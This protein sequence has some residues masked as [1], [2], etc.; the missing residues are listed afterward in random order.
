M[1]EKGPEQQPGRTQVTS[2][3][4][5]R[6]KRARFMDRLQARRAASGRPATGIVS[7]PEPR[8]AGQFARGKQLLAGN[9]RFAGHLIEAPD[10]SPWG[11]DI[12][13][14]AYDD[15]L[16]GFAWLDD[17]GA[18][19]DGK[20]RVAA[21]AWVT[22]WI[23]LYGNGKGPGWTPDLTGRRLI[24]WIGHALMILRAQDKAV[25]DRF[26]RS[27]AQQTIFL[28]RRSRSAK[29]GLPRFE[30]LTGLIYASLSLIGMD[31][32]LEAAVADLER[33]CAKLIDVDGALV[34]RNPEELLEVFTLLAWAA[35][36]LR[37]NDRQ[38]GPEH[39]AALNRIAPTIRALR[40]ADG[41]LAR[42]HGG[43]RG[44]DG[45]LD[46]AL[47]TAENKE[48]P[49]Q[50][51]YMGYARASAGRCTV[52]ADFAPPPYGP[53]CTEA[54]A[55]TLAFELTSGRRPL[56]VNC[57]H[58]AHFGDDWRRA[59]RATPS[60]STLTLDGTS[61][62]RIE[63]NR[64]GADVLVPGP[65]DVPWDISRT[66]EMLRLEAGHD[67]WRA[68]HG[69]THARTLDLYTDGRLFIGEDI[70]TTLAEEDETRFDATLDA[71]KLQGIPF[72]LRFHLHPDVNAS[73]DMNGSAV[74]L[75]LRS[76]EIWIFRVDGDVELTL[77]PSVYLENGRLRPRSSTQVVLSGTVLSYSTR[78]RWAFSKA[79]E[80]P[81]ASRDVAPSE[82]DWTDTDEDAPTTK[83]TL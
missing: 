44:V 59:G 65:K 68:S 16:H 32:Y 58:G 8:I 61:S 38:P 49:A 53:D 15:A 78:I 40:H 22:E 73:L 27:A 30:A 26:Y 29:P 9:F 41:S 70:I 25:A 48:I 1:V 82:D 57:G 14:D 45:R 64:D 55:A 56:V 60:H 43:G 71:R 77:E 23:D 42:F 81:I 54:H 19:G 2:R 63:A 11:L 4:H 17:L 62:A 31:G 75:G 28:S 10:Q 3:P 66:A 6:P 50:K 36:A 13:S 80:T 18:V 34:S 76:G 83:G 72:T 79:Q 35:S 20:A 12:P 74:S 21:S 47:S 52:I 39:A 37:E 46:W 69:L 67:G 24:R 33:D 51:L 7:Q 5:I